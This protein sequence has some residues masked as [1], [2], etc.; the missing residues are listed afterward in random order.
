M[1]KIYVNHQREGGYLTA[2]AENGKLVEL[3][4]DGA[5]KN[6]SVSGNIYAG[7]VKKINAGFIFLDVGLDCQ[8]FLDTRDHKERGLFCD[9]KLMVKQGDTLTVQVL[10]DGAGGKGPLATSNIS[11]A[12]S[13]VVLS[14]SLGHDKISVSRKISDETEIVRLKAIGEKLVP[15]GFSAIMRSAAQNRHEDEIMDEIHTVVEKFAAHTNWQHIKGPATL[16]AEPPIIKTLREV[17]DDSIDEIVVDDAATYEILSD[18]YG[19]KM[20]LYSEEEPFFSRFF[21]KTQIDKLRDKRV[22]LNSGAFIVIEQTEACVVIDVN[23]GK[24]TAKKGNTA[25]KV[26]MEAAK[27][28]AYQ[29]RLRNL[30]GIIIVDFIAMKSANDAHSLTEFLRTEIGKDRIPAV[31]VGMTALGLMEITRKRVRPPF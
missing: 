12:G 9:D 8:A 4:R 15:A 17:A 27:E 2:L 7:I 25:L 5:D 3:I 1:R 6:A 30:S 28:I 24:I 21:L 13:F 18:C 20:R 10:R 14:K 16:L 22:W 23:S 11:Y 29:L 19:P 26:N 31:V